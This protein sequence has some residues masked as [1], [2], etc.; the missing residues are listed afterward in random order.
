MSKARF[1]I[2]GLPSRPTKSFP[3]DIGPFRFLL[4]LASSQRDLTF[5][6]ATLTFCNQLHMTFAFL[7]R[8]EH[9]EDSMQVALSTWKSVFDTFGC[10][11]EEKPY[12]KDVLAITCLELLDCRELISA[13][14][15]HSSLQS[16]DPEVCFKIP[17]SLGAFYSMNK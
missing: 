8:S 13:F 17:R 3:A 14:S 7:P 9:S 16:S 11:G 10:F 4:S 5:T 1:Y 15:S 12:V 6:P 2:P